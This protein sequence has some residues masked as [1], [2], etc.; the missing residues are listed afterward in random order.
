MS[1]NT[2]QADTEQISAY[3][4]A[5]EVELEKMQL[6]PRNLSRYPF[7]HV[8]LALLSKVFSIGR[9][10]VLLLQNGFA[11]EAFSLSRSIVECGLNLRFITQ[12]PKLQTERTL[13]YVTFDRADKQLWMHHALNNAAD[14]AA[15]QSILNYAS[16]HDLKEDTREANRHWSGIKGFAWNVFLD[17]HPLDAITSTERERKTAHAV[18]YYNPTVFL[19]CYSPVI[20]AFL[21]Q[22]YMPYSVTSGT[23]GFRGSDKQ[24]LLNLAEYLH[25]CVNYTLFGMNADRPARMEELF[26]EALTFISNLEAG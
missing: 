12:E 15:Q 23:R 4:S 20:A 3:I 17:P 10:L 11:Q 21:P 26:A 19:H 13:R 25:D 9:S 16:E 18:Q 6:R 22:E 14:N 8:G 2:N 7:D 5:L 1:A 24:T